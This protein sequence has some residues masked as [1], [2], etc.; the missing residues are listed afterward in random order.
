MLNL[1]KTHSAA[2]AG[3]VEWL[4]AGLGNP[5][6][7]YD[8]T[9]HNVGF[10]AL[11]VLAAK[12]GCE[13]KKLRFH[14]LYGEGRVGTHRVALLKPQ[15][16]MNSSGESI[17]E[18]LAWYKLPP[19]RLIVLHDDINLQPGRIRIRAKGSAGGQNGLKS[20]IFQTGSDQFPRVKIGVG[21]PPHAD[22]DL[23]DWVLGTFDIADGR[24]VTDAIRRAA[25]AA[26]EIVENGP[27][28][29][30]NIYNQTIFT[31]DAK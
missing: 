10:L 12:L 9:R 3:P 15:T 5:G 25:D 19:E 31:P 18:A 22:Y 26:C 28:S 4:I 2:P 29:A 7:Q 14:G 6:N 20:I 8:K 24:A 27:V 16:F 11:D 1:F 13:V 30:A 23:A 17:R 21:T